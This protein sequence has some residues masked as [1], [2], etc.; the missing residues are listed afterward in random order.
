MKRSKKKIVLLIVG[1]VALVGLVAG[2]IAWSKRGVVAVQTG[3]VVRQDLKAIAT[4]NGE[5]KPPSTKFA[6]VNANSYGK[7]M[8]ISVKEGDQVKKGQLL[9][10]TESVQQEADVMGQEAALL[11]AQADAQGAESAVHSAAAALRTAQAELQQAQANSERAR[12]DFAR[13]EQMLA[14]KLIAQQVFDQRRNEHEVA[15]ASLEA[16][17]AR[18]S[19]ARALHQQALHSRDMSRAR[20]EQGRASLLRAR[21]IKSK[22]EYYSPL[23]GILTSLPVHEGENVVPGIQ[24]QPGSLLYQVSDLSVITAEVKVDETDIV[25][26]KLGQEAEVAID[27]IPEKTFNGEVTE[28]GQSAIGRT[29]GLTSGQSSTSAEEAKDFKVVVTIKDPP[30]GLRPGLSTTAKIVTAT[31]DDVVTVPI[32]ALTVRM[33][34]DLEPKDKDKKGTGE[35]KAAATAPASQSKP[36]ADKKKDE[37]DKEKEEVQGVFA[38]RNRRAVYVPVET[39][40]MGTKD[41]EIV[42]GLEPGEEIVTGSYRVLRTLKPETKV[43]IEKEGAPPGGEPAS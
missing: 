40:I 32:Q 9:L 29:S 34:R 17:Q 30:P 43:K 25:N 11:T 10:R 14:D 28:I 41:I 20:V 8:E 12:D 13:A 2:G 36:E 6:N 22:T 4:A 18:V 38:V 7:I 16:A 42:K 31:R 3:K 24:N 26:V 37:K 27:A 35:V 21:D 19:Q 39:G 15:A 5:I 33:R 23:D 1:A